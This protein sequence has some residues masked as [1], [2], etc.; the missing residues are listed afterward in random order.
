MTQTTTNTTHGCQ[1]REEY[2]EYSRSV[3]TLIGATPRAAFRSDIE[4]K[5]DER[6]IELLG[7][8]VLAGDKKSF[9][10]VAKQFYWAGYNDG[11]RHGFTMGRR[12]GQ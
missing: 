10:E 4:E 9:Y 1:T 2:E 8:K 6:L 5:F 3:D 12:N 7:P 11:D